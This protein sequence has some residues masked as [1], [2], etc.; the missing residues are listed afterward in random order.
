[1]LR[2]N[3]G[4]CFATAPAILL[5]DEQIQQVLND[6]Y[7]LLTTGKLKRIFGG[8]EFSAPMSL[9]SGSGDLK[10]NLQEVALDATIWLSPGLMKAFESCGLINPAEGLEAKTAALKTLI[11]PHLYKQGPI[12]IEELIRHVLASSSLLFR[13]KEAQAAFKG[14][15]DNALLKAWE[16]TLASFSEVKMEFSKWNLYSSLGLHPQE[17]Q[18]IGSV[19]YKDLEA[20]LEVNN[21]KIQRYQIDYEIAFDQVRATE[22]LLKQASSESQMR[23]LQ[24]EHQARLYH[25]HACLEMRDRLHKDASNYSTFFSFLTKQY[26]EKFQEYFQEI[27]D[28][29]MHDVKTGPYEDSPAGFRLVFKHGR[30]EASLW[31]LIYD[32]KQYI[33]ALVEF[34]ISIEHA[35][36]HACEWKTGKEQITEITTRLVHHLRTEEFLESALVRMAKAHHAPLPKAPLKMLDK[37]EKKPWAYTSGGTMTTLLK[38]YFKREKEMTE[39]SRWVES[40][41]D[42]LIFILDTLKALPPMVMD[43]Y[44]SDASLGMLMHSPTHAFILLPGFELFKQGWHDR[45]FTYTWVRDE[46]LYPRRDFCSKILLSF[47]QQQYLFELFCKKLPD[48]L[49]IV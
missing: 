30:T 36:V 35:L 41:I 26:E 34:F 48:A 37:L 27:Y 9:T 18:G 16:F 5:L 47:S 33:D 2:Q 31:T 44:L 1:M 12:A 32:H 49:A 43:P 42:L 19:I 8:I 14:L 6:L 4:S 28:P 11:L 45:G 7:E 22:V 38:T 3:V 46:C 15:V 10:K 29:D 21:E 39:E 20:K 23:R 13:E 24:A 25:M 17:E 40:P